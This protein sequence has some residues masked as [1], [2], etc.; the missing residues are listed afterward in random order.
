MAEKKLIP[1]RPTK[2]STTKPKLNKAPSTSAKKSSGSSKSSSKSSKKKEPKDPYKAAEARA[3]KKQKERD[4]KAGKK[5][6]EQAGNLDAQARAIRQA[7][8]VDFASARD[9]NLGDIGRMLQ[10]QI[11]ALQTGHSQRAKT[12]LDAATDTEVATSA[13]QEES[14]GNAV[15]ERADTLTNILTQGA[16]ETDTMRAMLMAAKNW[17]ANASEANRAYFDSMRSVNSGIVD[18]NLDTKAELSKAHAGAEGERD[19]VW[20][21]FYNRRAEAFT[22]IGNIRGQQKDYYASAKELGVKPKKG[23]EKAADDAMKK[24]FKDSAV[25]SGKSYTQQAL[26]NW[27]SDYQGQDQVKAAQSNSN[28][29][30]AVTL[31]PMAK[32]EGATLRKWAS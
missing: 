7:L 12:F 29:A 18:L 28:L 5:Y 1:I 4:K 13:T 11:Q 8:N 10:S 16:G 30:A 23:T 27:I 32:A 17:N 6:L 25:E 15:R 19:R 24:A 3:D 26:P 21:D 31:D 22:Q 9:N 2:P 20:Q 14:F